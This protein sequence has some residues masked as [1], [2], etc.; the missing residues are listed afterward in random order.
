MVFLKPITAE[1]S[2]S[3]A[4]VTTKSGQEISL[5]LVSAGK[6]AINARVDFV[7]EYHQRRSMVIPPETQS[8]VI[9][10]IRPPSTIGPSSSDPLK[11]DPLARELTKQR[12]L[13]SPDWQGKE[14]LAATGAS[15]DEHHQ[16][17][18]GFSVLNS[19]KRVVELLPPQLELS[20]NNHGKSSKRTKAEPVVVAE[21]RL[22]TRRLAPGQRADGVV[23]FE[24]P[25]FKESSERLQLQLAEAERVDRPILLPVPF[26][27][28]SVGGTQ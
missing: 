18:L 24:R 26:T 6:G 15:V 25:A 19:T 3:N 1:L 9:A 14:V 23:V 2:E 22:T 5:Q 21:Y 13:S 27:A 4:L 11:P 28:S 20:S 7:V 16:T 17:I 8:L 12:S 10:E